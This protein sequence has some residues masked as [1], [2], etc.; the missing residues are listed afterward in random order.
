MKNQRTAGLYDPYLDVMG[1]GEKHILSILQVLE[2]EGYDISLFWNQNLTSSIKNKLN[3]QFKNLTFIPNIFTS[4]SPVEKIK[5]LKNFDLFFYVTDGS[6]FVSSAKKNIIFCMVPN[7]KLYNMNIVNRLKTLNTLFISNSVYTQHWLQKWGVKSDVIYPYVTND[8]LETKLEIK[9]EKIILSVGRFF[10]HLHAKKH[11]EII[12]TFLT[13]QKTHEDFKLI[14]IGGLKDEDKT[15]FQSLVKLVG[16]NK[17]IILKPNVPYAELLEYYRK[18]R[19]FWHFA[20][21]GVDEEKH[22]E[23][24]EH[25]G[26]TPLEAMAAGTVP[27]C[28]EAGGPKE[29]ITD[30]ENGYLFKNEDELLSKI[31]K[32]LKDSNE[33]KK[34]QQN[35]QAYV[36]KYFS[37]AVFEERV[38]KI[39]KF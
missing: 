28:Y 2:K 30:G 25:L 36:K 1:G 27:F 10:G 7:I 19:F 4:P 23:M 16:D 29:I 38:N 34:V 12:K 39:F 8:L 37:F 32:I 9:K 21:Y 33:H 24:V 18:S 20:G 26:M 14:L 15:Y 17:N 11:E 6:Y 35:G 5:V 3:L 13:F 31:E 22:P